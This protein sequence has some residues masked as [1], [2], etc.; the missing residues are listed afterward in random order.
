MYK[1]IIACLLLLSIHGCVFKKYGRYFNNN[2][3]AITTYQRPV[4]DEKTDV[5]VSITIPN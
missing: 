2:K 3:S 4:L 5:L 1:A